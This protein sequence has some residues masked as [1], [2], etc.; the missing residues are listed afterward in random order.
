MKHDVIIIGSGLGGLECARILSDAGMDVLVLERDRQPGGCLQSYR[1]GGLSFDT[2]FHYVGGIGEGQSLGA[3]FRM[4][5]LSAL[6]WKRMDDKFDRIMIGDRSFS[7]SQGYENFTEALIREFPGEREAIEGYVDLLKSMGRQQL[8]MLN[9]DVKTD[10]FSSFMFVTGAWEY[11]T[12]TFRNRM[13]INVLSAASLKMELRKDTLPLFN[14]LHGNGSFVESSWRLKGDGSLIATSLIEGIRRNGGDVI[15]SAEVSSL[16]E[17]D[18]KII[19]AVCSDGEAYEGDIFI[20]DVHPAITSGWIGQSECVKKTYR[21]RMDSLENTFGML[22]VS[23][24]IKPHTLGYFNWNEYVYRDGDVWDFHKR[25]TPV[26]GILISA[27]VPED[28]DGYL[29]RLDILTPMA[30]ENCAAWEDTRTGRRGESYGEM[31]ARMAEECICLAERA[32]PGLKDAVERCYVSTPLT[33]RD[34][35]SAPQ[36]SAFGIRKDFNS[37]LTTILSPRTPIS[38]LLL[39]GHNLILHGIHGVTMTSMLT[40]SEILGKKYIWNRLN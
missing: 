6:P 20:S 4:L 27:G 22:T 35:T 39:T 15:C 18:R 7:Y 28:E 5:G 38:N 11:L 32:I 40:C 34:Y 36:G 12:A 2:G 1:R 16:V 8:D 33:W 9:P 30:W 23:L 19:H 37:P 24:A 14:F 3:A 10:P 21:K 31:K 25:N 29:Q 26:G 17:K 13:L